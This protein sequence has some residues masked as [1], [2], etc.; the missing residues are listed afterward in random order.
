MS[1]TTPSPALHLAGNAYDLRRVHDLSLPVTPDVTTNAFSLPNATFEP[2]R[3]GSF[4]GSVEEGG[5]VR[6]DIV[7]VAPHGNGT[8]TECVGHIA[9]RQYTVDA[10]MTDLVD[11]ATLVSVPLVEVGGDNVVTR[12]VLSAVWNG[13]STTTLIIRTLPNDASKRTRRWSETN[14]PYVHVD[15]MRLIVERGIRHLMIDLPSVDR[16]EDAGALLAHHCFW[17]WPGSPRT[18]C[19]ITELIY[20]PDNLRDGHYAV[21]FN[22]APFHGDAA[23]SR[24]MLICPIT[25][26]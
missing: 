25:N 19:T 8:H 3:A 14:P 12:D 6:C 24:P 10:C 23:P 17:Q 2:V 21:M 4:I 26:C 20:V 15:A 22:V 5:P 11:A 7:T 13:A 16:E 1:T 18:D 9:G